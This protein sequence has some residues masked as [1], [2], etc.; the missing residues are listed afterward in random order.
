MKSEGNQ[1]HG[2]SHFVVPRPI[3]ATFTAIYVKIIGLGLKTYCQQKTPDPQVDICRLLS[4]YHYCAIYTLFGN[5][6][7]KSNT[8]TEK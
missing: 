5:M 3:V 7:W 2:V 8:Q 6:P 1:L 4:I